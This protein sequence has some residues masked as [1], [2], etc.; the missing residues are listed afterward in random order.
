[1]HRL[2]RI[3]AAGVAVGAVGL[4]VMGAEPG[5]LGAETVA[6][7]NP[8]AD[9]DR[10]D[11]QIQEALGI[12]DTGADVLTPLGNIL[13]KADKRVQ[14][15]DAE[16]DAVVAVLLK[17][18]HATALQEKLLPL[19][20]VGATFDF[21]NGTKWKW[22]SVSQWSD[23]QGDLWKRAENVADTDVRRASELAKA[24]IMLAAV[25]DF[26]RGYMGGLAPLV[27][28]PG[29]CEKILN[30]PAGQFEKLGKLVAARFQMPG[31]MPIAAYSAIDKVTG[32]D[33]VALADVQKALD[34]LDEWMRKSPRC[35]DQ[36]EALDA[37]WQLRNLMR[38]RHSAEG[39][40]AVEQKML[41]WKREYGDPDVQRWIEEALTREG[42]PPHIF[43]MRASGH[44]AA[45]AK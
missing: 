5:A 18:P 41:G 13:G 2:I 29:K 27:N 21:S 8:G 1:M 20:Q 15:T 42:P 24:A 26:D 40:G 35:G 4:A 33:S 37:T 7:A 45:P 43:V 17:G 9:A 44:I 6:P 38:F 22:G 32:S 25:C 12:K 11:A 39:R 28:E 14:P 3:V 23:L 19:I 36:Y 16:V 10:L 30:L 31:V 34:Q